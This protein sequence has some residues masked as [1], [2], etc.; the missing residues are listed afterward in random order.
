MLSFHLWRSKQVYMLSFF[1]FFFSSFSNQGEQRLIC[2]LTLATVSRLVRTGLDR[3]G[4]VQT[5][6]DRSGL[7]YT[8][9][10]WFRLLLSDQF[11]LGTDRIIEVMETL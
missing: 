4:Q 6:P 9:T 3:S 10:D 1:L 2:N 11:C 8:G 5:G 7:V